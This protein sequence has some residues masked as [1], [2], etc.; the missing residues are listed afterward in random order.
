MEWSVPRGLGGTRWPPPALCSVSG[1]TL[2]CCSPVSTASRSS[3]DSAYLRVPVS[4]RDRLRV[5]ECPVCGIVVTRS[6]H[7]AACPGPRDPSHSAAPRSLHPFP[8]KDCACCSSPRAPEAQLCCWSPGRACASATR[9][10][11]PLEDAWGPWVSAP[12]REGQP[13]GTGLQGQQGTQCGRP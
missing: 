5:S 8:Q 11:E 3:E 7:L 1:R 6:P 9:V 2:N 10:P 4:C 12:R 13:T